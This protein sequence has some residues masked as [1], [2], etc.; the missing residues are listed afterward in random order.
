MRSVYTGLSVTALEL[1]PDQS[2]F[3]QLACIVLYTHALRRETY[4]DSIL[5][6]RNPHTHTE[7]SERQF[8]YVLNTLATLLVEPL[9][10]SRSVVS[11][12]RFHTNLLANL[13]Y[14]STVYSCLL[15]VFVG[16]PPYRLCSVPSPEWL[17]EQRVL[18]KETRVF[19]GTSS[20][21][22]SSWPSF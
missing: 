22:R 8:E 4:S 3:F 19:R 21:Y 13:F 9:G 17:S 14:S 15:Y 18:A 11:D 5:S 16:I 20:P 7:T 10:P 6:A 2:W 12:R 1:T